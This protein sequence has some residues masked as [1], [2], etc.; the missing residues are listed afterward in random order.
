MTETSFEGVLRLTTV[1]FLFVGL[2][3][4]WMGGCQIQEQK[5]ERLIKELGNRNEWV[6]LHAAM[7]LGQE[8]LRH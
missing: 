8:H 5:V 1:M 4:I 2:F 6:H 7:A 3:G